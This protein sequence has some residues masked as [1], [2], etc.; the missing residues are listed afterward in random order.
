MHQNA[1]DFDHRNAVGHFERRM[2]IIQILL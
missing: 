2:D 1:G